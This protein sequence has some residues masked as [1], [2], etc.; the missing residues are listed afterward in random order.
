MRQNEQIRIDDDAMPHDFAIREQHRA[1]HMLPAAP[2]QSKAVF[3]D[4]DFQPPHLGEAAQVSPA[5]LVE[6]ASEGMQIQAQDM[7]TWHLEIVDVAT[8]L[9]RAAEIMRRCNIG[10][11]PICDDGRPVGV[12]TDRDI[13]VRAT[14]DGSD[15]SSVRVGDVMTK[16]IQ[17]CFQDQEI[18]E[19][20]NQ[21]QSSQVRRILVVDRQGKLVG[22]VSLGDL[23]VSGDEVLSGKTLNRV[24]ESNEPDRFR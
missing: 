5:Q 4:P 19:V 17:T 10:F 18:H 23:S 6:T 2:W 3:S 14:A 16:D 24:S 13:T 12:L 1:T 8:S 20:A 9:Q 11:L 21:M 22:V 15:P 7:M